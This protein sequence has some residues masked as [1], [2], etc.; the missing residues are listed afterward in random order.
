MYPV[1][2]FNH[3]HAHQ[4]DIFDPEISDDENRKL[5]TIMAALA[6][7]FYR[8]LKDDS[9][10]AKGDKKKAWN[11]AFM[12]LHEHRICAYTTP[13]LKE[14]KTQSLF[15]NSAS[16]GERVLNFFNLSLN[17]HLNFTLNYSE[18]PLSWDYKACIEKKQA[19]QKDPFTPEDT[20]EKRF[21]S[22]FAKSVVRVYPEAKKEIFGEDSKSDKSISYN[23]VGSFQTFFGSSYDSIPLKG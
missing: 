18:S 17:Q 22:D 2:L 15:F 5:S 4:N 7:Q 19:F 16:K 20:P 11:A 13:I 8:I 14:Y 12:F 21:G 23:L 10:I 6:E 1:D 3:D 9:I